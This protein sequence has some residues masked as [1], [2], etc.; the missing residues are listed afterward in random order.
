MQRLQVTTGNRSYT[1]IVISEHVKRGIWNTHQQRRLEQVCCS[2][3][4]VYPHYHCAN[5]LFFL[6][7]K[8][9]LSTPL[10]L[11]PPM[12]NHLTHCVPWVSILKSGGPPDA[13]GVLETTMSIQMTKTRPSTAICQGVHQ[14]R[15]MTLGVT[16]GQGSKEASLWMSTW[17][18]L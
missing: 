1:T 2:L 3:K 4:S 14:W 6:V 10:P 17:W 8:S 12:A 9:C 15:M 5:N 18:T 13:K 7:L 16:E 11:E